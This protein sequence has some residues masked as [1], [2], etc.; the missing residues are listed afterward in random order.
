MNNKRKM[1]KMPIFMKS[2]INGKDNNG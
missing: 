1:K 2:N